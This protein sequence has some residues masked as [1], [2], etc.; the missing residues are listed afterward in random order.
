MRNKPALILASASPRRISLLKQIHITPDHIIPA[1]IDESPLAKELP[2]DHALRLAQEKAQTIAAKHPD[3][4]TLAADTV[5]AAGRRILPKTETEEDTRQCL[6]LLSGRS[7]R[8]YGGIALACP[9][10][11]LKS[12]VVET[13][14]HFKRL[15]QKEIDTYI[16]SQEWQGVAGGYA[17]QGLAASFIK[18]LNGSHS[19]VV[20][21]SLYDTMNMLIGAG[22]KGS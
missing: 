13:R 4:Y 12:R 11:T 6:T 3:A 7:H 21:L 19:N 18:S 22:Y 2:R 20:G 10:G 17:I 1:D 15:S 5:V 9:D 16:Q 8:V 14:L